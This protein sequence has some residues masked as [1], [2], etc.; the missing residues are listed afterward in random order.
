MSKICNAISV[1]ILLTYAS[2]GRAASCDDLREVGDTL[3]FA[4]PLSAIALTTLKGDWRQ[5]GVQM[6]K[7]F[8][9]TG[10]GAGFFKAVGDK[11]R[12][13]AGGSTQSF[14]SGHAAGAFMGASYIY[15]RYGKGWGVP[16]YSLALLTA[17]SRVCAQAHFADDVLGGAMVAMMANWYA[18]S[19]YPDAGRIYPSYTSNGLELSWKTLF[20]GN[21][22]PVDPVNFD[23]RYRMV[24]EFGAV[25]QDKNIVRAPGELGS[26]IDLVALNADFHMTA[27]FLFERYL[28][29]KHE[30]TVWYGPMGMT[31]FG[32]PEEPFRV[33]DEIFD[34]SDPD[35]EIF[36]T[37]YRW[38][39]LRAGY[40][41][42]L[43][44][45]ERWKFRV[46]A[47]LQVSR[48]EFEVEQRD[49]DANVVKSGHGEE[50]TVA[51]LLHLSGELHFNHRWSVSAEVDG[52]SAGD[53]YYWNTGVWLRYQPTQL[54]DLSVGGRL[55]DGKIDRDALFNE[56]KIKDIAFQIGRSF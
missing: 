34:P 23:R 46:G 49:I 17:Y 24:F 40:R 9:Y 39:D 11:S 16:A 20:G 47:S 42:N 37:N 30:L 26:T 7:T 52:I 14:V 22:H 4:L 2:T 56:V 29:E 51:P 19:P 15:T 32:Q 44:N 27:R 38:W 1:L 50:T 48:T 54:W 35:A 36:D 31:D 5:G 12:P 55:I 53:E 3:T 43:V 33:G 25:E 45:T 6:T 10:A 21:R 28:T 8:V 18:T 41:Y 13:N